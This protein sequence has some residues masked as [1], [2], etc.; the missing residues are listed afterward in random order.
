MTKK[1]PTPVNR[2]F[3]RKLTARKAKVCISLVFWNSRNC[4]NPLLLNF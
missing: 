1:V 3:V 2:H 4:L